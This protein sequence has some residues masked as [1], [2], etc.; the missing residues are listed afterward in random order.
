MSDDRMTATPAAAAG[1]ADAM[2]PGA[3]PVGKGVTEVRQ[4][5]STPARQEK[6]H[7]IAQD[8]RDSAQQC[9]GRVGELPTE[10]GEEK[11]KHGRRISV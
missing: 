11:F 6:K 7:R 9:F 5:D 1:A 3:W 2:L 8:G 4:H 10:E